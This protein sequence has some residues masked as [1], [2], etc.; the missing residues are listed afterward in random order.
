MKIYT[1]NGDKG[2]TQLASGKNVHKSHIR[3]ELCGVLDE[4]NS[5]IGLS[6]SFLKKNSILEPLLKKE[7][8]KLFDLGSYFADFRKSQEQEVILNSD[9]T[10]LEN[11]IDELS[12]KLPPLKNFILPGG[13]KSASFLHLARSIARRLE[14]LIVKAKEEIEINSNS[15]IYINRISDF[16][17]TAARF[18]N[19]E[20]KIQEIIWES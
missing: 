10:H 19:L 3:I 5:A 13:S 9:I 16:L 12:E 6:N 20:E 7:Q 18:A 1:R 2:T 11:Q 15:L 17:F 4:L 8:N 14:R